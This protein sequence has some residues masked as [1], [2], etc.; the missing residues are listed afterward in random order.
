M[1]VTLRPVPVAGGV[2][3]EVNRLTNETRKGLD[4]AGRSITS[5][6]VAAGRATMDGAR[7]GSRHR[8]GWQKH[9]GRGRVDRRVRHVRRVEPRVVGGDPVAATVRRTNIA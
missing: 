4:A 3:G 2:M 9:R 6:G 5:V 7:R 1:R 8:R